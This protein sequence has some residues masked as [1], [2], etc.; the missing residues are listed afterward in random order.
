MN[1]SAALDGA[2]RGVAVGP[3]QPLHV[4]AVVGQQVGAAQPLQLQPMLGPAQER[5]GGG[6]LGAVGAAD[7]AAA[8]Q[9]PQPHQG[10]GQPQV[11]VGPAVH[12]LQQLHR[13][14]DVPQPAG[15]E[16]E[17]PVPLPLR[18][19]VLDPAAHGLHVVDERLP[20]GRRPHPGRGDVQELAARAPGRRPPAGP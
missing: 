15:A 20:A 14:L 10:A 19:V 12:Q 2:G 4:G 9:R 3:G 17:L 11:G 1:T 16:L 5:V 13:E 7:V 8:D 6:H 18:D